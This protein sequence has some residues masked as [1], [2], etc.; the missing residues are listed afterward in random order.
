MCRSL[1]SFEG[2]EYLHSIGSQ[3][4]GE[5]EAKTKPKGGPNH[6][7]GVDFSCGRFES[8]AVRFL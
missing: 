2:F 1:R 8:L 5:V 6:G 7:M 4:E 3:A